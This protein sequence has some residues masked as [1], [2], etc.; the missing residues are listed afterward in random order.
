MDTEG[1]QAVEALLKGILR[2]RRVFHLQ[3]WDECNRFEGKVRHN[4]T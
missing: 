2:D 4:V 1:P 3:Q